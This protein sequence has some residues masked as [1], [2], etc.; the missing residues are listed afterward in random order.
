MS[1]L[2]LRAALAFVL[3][4]IAT[5]CLAA[6]NQCLDIPTGP[7]QVETKAGKP[8]TE[9]V[10]ALLRDA[11][12]IYTAGAGIVAR[13]PRTNAES[14]AIPNKDFRIV[15][16][17]FQG[18]I[19]SA[20]ETELPDRLPW[21]LIRIE[22]FDNFIFDAVNGVVSCSNIEARQRLKVARASLDHAWMEF[23]G[24]IKERE[25]DPNLDWLPET[26]EGCSR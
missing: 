2:Q 3:A 20:A 4:M 13:N 17:H 5:P 10:E 15:E 14:Y 16:C 9:V 24:N 11:E 19:S 21:T 23:K 22:Q 26:H 12:T 7:L 1:G 18:A 6:P 25:W 8:I